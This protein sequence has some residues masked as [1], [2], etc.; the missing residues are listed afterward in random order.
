[1]NDTKARSIDLFVENSV[2]GITGDRSPVGLE[3]PLQYP[4][5]DM[6]IHFLSDMCLEQVSLHDLDPMFQIFRENEL[7]QAQSECDHLRKRMDGRIFDALEC[8]SSE[9]A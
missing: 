7:Q 5:R 8:C 6:A 4:G 3:Y 1:M 2:A 9:L